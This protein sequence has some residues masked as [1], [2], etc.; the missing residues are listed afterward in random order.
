MAHDRLDILTLG[1][2][3]SSSD[4]PHLLGSL[5]SDDLN[6]NLM[7]FAG[8]NGIDEHV[9]REVDVL[10]VVLDG[11]G[12]VTVGGADTVL[13]AGRATI[14]PK[15]TARAIRSNGKRFAYLTCHGQRRGM[16][17]TVDGG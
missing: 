10:I 1:G 15:G 3:P 6:V 12:V 16:M 2:T 9:N 4:A 14:I 13:G 17:P 5:A 7:R 8:E 11:E